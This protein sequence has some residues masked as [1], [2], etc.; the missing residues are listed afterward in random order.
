[1]D[2]KTA[3]MG[4]VPAE[5]AAWCRPEGLRRAGALTRLV[6]QRRVDTQHEAAS[7]FIVVAEVDQ[8]LRLQP[9]KMVVLFASVT[10]IRCATQVPALSIASRVMSRARASCTSVSVRRMESRADETSAELPAC[11]MASALPDPGVA[12]FWAPAVPV[13]I[14]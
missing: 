14:R 6:N 12:S 2:R 9:V 4:V 13:V 5:Y 8:P 10:P 3:R 11:L 1:M 7:K